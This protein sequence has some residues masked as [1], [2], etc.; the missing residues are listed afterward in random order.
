MPALGPSP[1]LN[2]DGL[3]LMLLCSAGYLGFVWLLRRIWRRP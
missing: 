3:W 1:N 2:F